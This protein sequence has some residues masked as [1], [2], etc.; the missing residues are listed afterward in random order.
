M[1]KRRDRIPVTVVRPPVVYGPRDFGLF[2]LY[3]MVARGFRPEIGGRKV[4][5]IIHV[6]DLVDGIVRAGE[7]PAGAGE[8]FYLANEAA[9]EV[10][11][12]LGLIERALGKKAL[13]VAIPDRVVRFLGAVVEGGSRLAG[14]RILFGRDK[15]LEMTQKAWVCLPAKAAKVLGWRARIP[16]PAGLEEA[17]RWYQDERLL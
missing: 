16:F 10:S 15:A 4:I 12:V 2:D 3:R 11:A 8:I 17:V 7:A 14:K 9:V 1:W 13:R 5:S 6:R